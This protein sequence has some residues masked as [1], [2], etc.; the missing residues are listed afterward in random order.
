MLL[1]AI[2]YIAAFFTIT[3]L[4]TAA[5]YSVWDHSKHLQRNT[6]DIAH[7]LEAG[8][9]WRGE[10]RQATA[11]LQLAETSGAPELRIPQSAGEIVYVLQGDT[12]LRR[13]GGKAERPKVL[14]RIKTS[15]FFRQERQGVV[16]WRWELE[17]QSELKSAQV[18]PLFSFT[19]V[20]AAERQP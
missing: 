8:E 6:N 10:V 15:R 17:L 4:A 19:A 11:P 7:V 16:S 20:A 2:V 1:E 3:G 12:L 9:R 13:P 18:R 14:S 5:F